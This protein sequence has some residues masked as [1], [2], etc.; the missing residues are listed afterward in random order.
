[1]VQVV[2]PDEKHAD[3]DIVV[4]LDEA[5]AGGTSEEAQERGAVAA[6]ARVAGNRNMQRVLPQAF[7][8]AWAWCVQQVSAC[9]GH[10]LCFADNLGQSV[11]A[12]C[13]DIPS[14]WQSDASSVC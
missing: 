9:S 8:A 14:H 7:Q 6:L 3:Q 11:H 1:M 13:I 5:Q 4:F 10:M 2:L 12:V